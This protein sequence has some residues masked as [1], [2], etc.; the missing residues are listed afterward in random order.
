[1]RGATYLSRLSDVGWIFPEGGNQANLK[2]ICC[3]F[4][5]KKDICLVDSLYFKHSNNVMVLKYRFN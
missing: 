4:N 1:M 5:M 2:T 3:I